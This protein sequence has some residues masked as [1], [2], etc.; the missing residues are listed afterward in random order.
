MAADPFNSKSGYTVGIPP[1]TIIDANSN[2]Y[3]NFAT[4]GGNLIVEGNANVTGTMTAGLFKGTFDGNISGNI[5][6]PGMNTDVLFNENGNAGASTY[7]KFDSAARLLTVDG[8]VIANSITLG[9]GINQ[10]STQRVYFATTNSSAPDQVLYSIDA[11]L[12]L[13]IDFTVI[14]TDTIGNN[15]QTSKLF[16]SILGTEVGYYEIATIDVPYLGPGVGDFRVVY[17]SGN[18]ELTVQ[19]VTSELVDYRIMVTQYKD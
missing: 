18:V 14:A 17:N 2:V 1:Y 11:S 19:P 12:I 15:R 9:S 5:S 6:V 8:D 7:F 3:A 16:A 4:V 13:S 10:F